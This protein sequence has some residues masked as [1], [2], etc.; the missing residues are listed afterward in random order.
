M[1]TAKPRSGKAS[2]R[3]PP[4]ETPYQ[5]L[6]AA[7]ADYVAGDLK[8]SSANMW[9]A[10]ELAA[11]AFAK[12]RGWPHQT[13]DDLESAV[14]VLNKECEDLH[15]SASWAVVDTLWDNIRD[16]FLERGEIRMARPV[17]LRFVTQLMNQAA[18]HD[19]SA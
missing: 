3:K 12:S 1:T 7:A 4:P 2:S 10:S 5:Y 13:K 8:G 18:Q 6:D 16:D 17:I 19:P 11:T 14:R 15:L 9:K